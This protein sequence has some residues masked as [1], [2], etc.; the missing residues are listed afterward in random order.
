M[1]AKETIETLSQFIEVINSI[2]LES[3]MRMFPPK[4]LFRGQSQAK[5]ELVPSLGRR[6]SQLWANSWTTVEKDF[7]RSAQQKFPLLFLDSDYPVVL[8]SKLQHYGIPTRLLDITENALVA[9]YF[10]CNKDD[11]MDG[12]V[13][14]FQAQMYSAY[15]PLPNI[16]AD[17]YRLTENAD[18]PIENYYF[19]A[20]HRPYA[21]RWLY[22]GWEED[23]SAGL[24]LLSENMQAPVFIQVGNI[25]ERQKN[26]SGNFILFPNKIVA[27]YIRDS[28]ISIEKNDS[29][30]VR[31]LIIPKEIKKDLILQLKRLG[32][33]EDFLFADNVDKV[34]EAIVAEQRRRYPN[35]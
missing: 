24:R 15:D 1:K 29:C 8:L 12:E 30:V 21:A 27:E 19:R 23:M 35:S 14:A 11:N 33:T 17:T 2:T 9:L 32:I 13:F 6:P 26:Q 7:V 18:I 34:L 25:C 31:Q 16:V 5:F 20:M 10:A 3:E 22:P 4:L 28:L